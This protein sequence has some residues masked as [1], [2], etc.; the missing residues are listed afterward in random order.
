MSTTGWQFAS[1]YNASGH[2]AFYMSIDLNGTT[3]GT[4]S[5]EEY[6]ALFNR[7]FN[8][9]FELNVTDAQTFG[10]S[11]TDVNDTK[12]GW[13]NYFCYSNA[14]DLNTTIVVFVP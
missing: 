9:S 5:D 8:T 6:C 13:G 1:D 11:T 12:A 14:D 4:K 7:E 3:T 10:L 2:P